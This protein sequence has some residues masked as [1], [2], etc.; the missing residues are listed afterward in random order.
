[1]MIVNGVE[2]EILKEIKVVLYV[3]GFYDSVINELL[4]VFVKRFGF[5]LKGDLLMVNVVWLKFE[6]KLDFK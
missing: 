5:L 3:L 6:V 4:F 1:M 2:G